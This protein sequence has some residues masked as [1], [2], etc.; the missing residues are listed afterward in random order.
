[1]RAVGARSKPQIA[2]RSVRTQSNHWYFC[3]TSRRSRHRLAATRYVDVGRLRT[4]NK[5]VA[6]ELDDR[7]GLRSVGD[8]ISSL[9][10]LWPSGRDPAA[11]KACA[12]GRCISDNFVL[13]PRVPFICVGQSWSGKHRFSPAQ[14]ST[15]A[16]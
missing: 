13:N 4:A 6:A 11:E 5:D 10:W 15:A 16:V 9:G 7:R 12:T 14:R 1:S 3:L 8:V 2:R